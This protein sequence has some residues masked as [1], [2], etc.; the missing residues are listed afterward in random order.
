[1]AL[2]LGKKSLSMAKSLGGAAKSFIDWNWDL[3]KKTPEK[4]LGQIYDLMLKIQEEQDI[5]HEL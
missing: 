4:V 1:M 5:D 3:N 2:E